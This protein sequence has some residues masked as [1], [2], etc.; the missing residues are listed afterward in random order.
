MLT[1]PLPPEASL[2]GLQ[3][4]EGEA[5][6]PWWCSLDAC[7]RSLPR[8]H[9]PKKGRLKRGHGS[10]NRWVPTAALLACVLSKSNV[11]HSCF[12]ILFKELTFK[13]RKSYRSKENVCHPGEEK[14]SPYFP[15]S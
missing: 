8:G 7:C 6:A 13:T 4:A 10:V 15:L 9:K 5:G 3:F 1:R 14:M 12:R 11:T 2:P